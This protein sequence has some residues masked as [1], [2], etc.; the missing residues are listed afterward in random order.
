MPTNAPR[1]RRRTGRTCGTACPPA[2]KSE[3]PYCSRGTAHLARRSSR[4][5]RAA[6]R[7]V[8]ARRGPEARPPRRGTVVVPS[9]L[10]GR[11]SRRMQPPPLVVGR[12]SRRRMDR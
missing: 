8:P 6:T 5:R 9:P 3:L 11:R 10:V 2:R 7:R 1:R 4:R 12:C